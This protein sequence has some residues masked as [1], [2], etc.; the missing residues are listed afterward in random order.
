MMFSLKNSKEEVIDH[1][2]LYHLLLVRSTRCTVY[3][4]SILPFLKAGSLKLQQAS[5]VTVHVRVGVR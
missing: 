1:L 5:K 4:I 2:L 3:G